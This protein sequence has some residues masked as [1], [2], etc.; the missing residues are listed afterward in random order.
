[1][2][3]GGTLRSVELEDLGWVITSGETRKEKGGFYMPGWT[4]AAEYNQSC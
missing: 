3:R 4:L 1:M 2:K